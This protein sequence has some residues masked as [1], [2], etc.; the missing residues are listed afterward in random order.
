LY[1]W[2]SICAD[3]ERIVEIPDLENIFMDAG[4]ASVQ[5]MPSKYNAFT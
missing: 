2:G 1:P 4:N 5:S 3:L